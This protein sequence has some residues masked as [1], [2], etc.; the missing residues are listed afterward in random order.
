M[1]MY[2]FKCEKVCVYVFEEGIPWPSYIMHFHILPRRPVSAVSTGE[3]VS[4]IHMKPK[5]DAGSG[6]FDPHTLDI[7][8]I[9]KEFSCMPG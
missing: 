3:S 4:Y 8:R 7:M 1:Y 9:Q 5:L 2:V 6:L